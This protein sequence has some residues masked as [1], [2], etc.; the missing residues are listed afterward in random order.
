MHER[1]KPLKPPCL[2]IT[3][4]VLFYV[5][6]CMV[7]LMPKLFIWLVWL[8]VS[9]RECESQN[10]RFSLWAMLEPELHWKLRVEFTDSAA[11]K[12]RAIHFCMVVNVFV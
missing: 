8:L 7:F 12:D 3:N 5:V 9:G 6:F 1:K 11:T 10:S 4:V 2:I